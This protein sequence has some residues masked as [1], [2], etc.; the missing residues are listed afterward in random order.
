MIDP[1][2]VGV[3]GLVVKAAVDIGRDMVKAHQERSSSRALK[4]QADIEEARTYGISLLKN[5]NGADK[6]SLIAFCPAHID[7]VQRIT[8][9]ENEAEHINADLH[10][11]KDDVKIIRGAMGK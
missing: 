10:E 5:K 3:I 7:H 9:L 11:I 8:T 2:S 4:S 1:V 6:P